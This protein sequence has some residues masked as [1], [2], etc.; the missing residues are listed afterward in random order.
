MSRLRQ[1]R[2]LIV[3][4]IGLLTISLYVPLPYY[5][6]RPGS[7]MELAPIISVEGGKKDEKGAFML[8]TVRMGQANVA[9]YLYAK[10]SPDAELIDRDLVLNKGESNEDYTKREL[11]VMQDS[12]MTAEAMA[13]KRAGYPVKV[14][15]LGVLVNGTLEGM[16]AAKVLKVGDIL[17]QVDG[18]RIT[19]TNELF[20]VL[21]SKKPGD[22]IA[23]TYLRDKQELKSSLVL[24]TLPAGNGQPARAGFGIRPADKT[25]IEVPKKVNITSENIGGPSAGL[26]F[27]LE[28]YDQLKPDIDLTKGYR[29]AGT[30]TI[31]PDA[32]VGRIGGINHKIIAAQNAGADIFFAPD[33]S[34]STVSNYQEALATAKRIGA[35]MKIVPVK[36]LDDA[37]VYL[38]ALIPKQ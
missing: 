23:L 12:Q 15:K 27:T 11:G 35:K 3:F 2:W 17:T 18:K 10:F 30:G 5:V 9:W 7:A 26:M 16:P 20:A 38:E 32:T 6:T 8:T 31:N 33:D 37:V 13:F 36:K 1:S 4:L 24:V 34:D 28:I 25:L 29:I 21:A 19:D 14:Q 22:S